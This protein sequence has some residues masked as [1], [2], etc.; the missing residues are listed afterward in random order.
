MNVHEQ[1]RNMLCQALDTS[2]PAEA[3]RWADACREYVGYV[4]VGLELFTANG[5]LIVYDLMREGFRVFLDLKIH[6]I[7]NTSLAAIRNASQLQVSFLTIH[8]NALIQILDN[9]NGIDTLHK[10]RDN[11]QILGVTEL[12]SKKSLDV[13]ERGT[14][15][16]NLELLCLSGCNGIVCGAPDLYLFRNVTKA[17]RPFDR[18]FCVTPAI[19]PVWAENNDQ[20][21]VMSPGDAIT[22]GS[23]LLVLGRP[24]NNPPSHI[25]NQR[26]AAELVHEEI[27]NALAKRTF[28]KL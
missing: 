17:E 7:P 4:K 6:D 28:R 24:I 5:P 26:R 20:K 16:Q 15:M 3:L 13:Y 11:T 25:G 1:A 18:L 10:N 21:R 9:P 27:C 23:D 19:R 22:A 2:D 14:F 12:T 8:S